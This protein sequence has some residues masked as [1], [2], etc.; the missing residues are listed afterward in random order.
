MGR[1]PDGVID[2]SQ[3]DVA[4]ALRA[5]VAL[6]SL[7]NLRSMISLLSAAS[8][9]ELLAI[10]QALTAG[11]AERSA[12]QVVHAVQRAAPRLAYKRCHGSPTAQP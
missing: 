4:A 11:I 1:L 12:D 2:L 3:P 6:G 7:D 9:G 8:T 10:R 5:M